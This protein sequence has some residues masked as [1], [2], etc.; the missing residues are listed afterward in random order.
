MDYNFIEVDNL[1]V[2]YSKLGSGE[3][4]I[5]L[6]GIWS[7]SR[8]YLKLL[9]ELSKNYT[10]YALDLPGFGKSSDPNE[11]WSFEDYSEFLYKFVK[12]LKLNKFTLVAHSGAGGIAIIFANNHPLSLNRL[13]LISAFGV[14]GVS[15]FTFAKAILVKSFVE[16]FSLRGLLSLS[17][18]ISGAIYNFFKHGTYIFKLI[19]E[20]K[21]KNMTEHIRNIKVNTLL[22]WGDKDEYF[23]LSHARKFNQLIKKSELKILKGNHDLCLMYPEKIKEFL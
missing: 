21:N 13:V 6:H 1:N 7:Y 18:T 10:V 17:Y 15:Y 20:N 23:P 2:G 11:V 8:T 16:L 14:E 5:L 9:K 22:L 12:K 4:L 19:R 3:D